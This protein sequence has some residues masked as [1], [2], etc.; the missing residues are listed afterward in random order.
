[1]TMNAPNQYDYNASNGMGNTPPISTARSDISSG[2][3]G[4]TNGIHYSGSNSVTGGSSM[5]APPGNAS[6]SNAFDDL[7]QNDSS[8]VSGAGTSSLPGYSMSSTADGQLNEGGYGMSSTADIQKNADGYGMSTVTD[9]QSDV[10]EYGASAQTQP[11]TNGYV[12]QADSN[13]HFS[14]VGYGVP[15]TSDNM[16]EQD[17]ASSGNSAQYTQ[18]N[19]NGT[20]DFSKETDPSKQQVQPSYGGHIHSESSIYASKNDI[21]AGTASVSMMP[22]STHGTENNVSYSQIALSKLDDDESTSLEKLRGIL[23]QLKAENISL[24][25][26]FSSFSADEAQ[27]KEEIAE[28]VSDIGTLSQEISTL[29]SNIVKAKT[30]LVESTAA[31]KEEFEKKEK[32]API[33]DFF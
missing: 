10:G 4:D 14:G 13:D 17:K 11:N 2:M 24:R 30:S 12:V 15:S 21:I 33:P 3:G 16:T 23:Q 22:V 8:S 5:G 19:I 28:T 1:M 7:V 32:V 18:Q 29:R 27:V 6:I 25:A 9:I 20:A 26:Q 31:L